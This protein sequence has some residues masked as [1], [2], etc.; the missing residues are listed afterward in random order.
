MP[1]IRQGEVVIEIDHPR[2]SNVLF[3]PAQSLL[4]ADNAT[5][6]SKIVNG[7]SGPGAPRPFVTILS[8][9]GQRIHVDPKSGKARITD[10]LAD[11]ENERI[12]TQVKDAAAKSENIRKAV[13]GAQKEYSTTL[14][15]VGVN[16]W[17]FWMARLVD[18]G[19]AVQVNGEKLKRAVEYR[20]A[21][22]VKA[23]STHPRW[24]NM[25]YGGGVLPPLEM[26]GAK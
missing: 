5:I 17:L 6:R 14:D 26:A 8:I 24:T 7:R 20:K 25:E 3:F 12:L 4:P 10:A 9:P 19:H 2:N 18:D 1:D 15:T 22:N 21:G 11:K 23:P 16:N 13:S